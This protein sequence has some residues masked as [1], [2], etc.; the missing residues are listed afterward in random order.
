MGAPPDMI[1]L[2]FAIGIAVGVILTVAVALFLWVIRDGNT[3]PR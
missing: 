2:A 3:R 1:S